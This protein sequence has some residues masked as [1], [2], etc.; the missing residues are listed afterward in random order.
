MNIAFFFFL[1]HI[2]WSLFTYL[3]PSRDQVL[4]QGRDHSLSIRLLPMPVLLNACQ[5]ENT[6]YLT[7]SPLFIFITCLV[8]RR[9]G[10]GPSRSSSLVLQ[11]GKQSPEEKSTQSIT[12]WPTSWLVLPSYPTLLWWVFWKCKTILAWRRGGR[13]ICFVFSVVHEIIKYK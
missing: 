7:Q 11:M 4:H 3:L 12:I 10:L 6:F 2:C 8:C 5:V 13:W 1:N 9:V